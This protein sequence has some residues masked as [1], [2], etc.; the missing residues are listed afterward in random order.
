M[1]PITTEINR[2]VNFFP[3]RPNPYVAGQPGAFLYSGNS[4]T[5]ACTDCNFR[6]ELSLCRFG[7]RIGV[8]YSINDKTVLRAGWGLIYGPTSVNPLGVNA[9][10]IVNTL[11]KA[12]LAKAYRPRPWP[13][14]YRWFLHFLRNRCRWLPTVQ[15]GPPHRRRVPL[16]LTPDGLPDR[17]EWSVGIQRELHEGS[18]A[19]TFPTL[20][21]AVSGGKHLRLVDINAVHIPNSWWR[22]GLI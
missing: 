6:T 9:A 1:A 7:P 22:T 20:P 14:G 18:G 4:G 19:R 13:W 21:I 8:A 11:T 15:S 17:I 2:A 3:N 10:G 5:G 12:S 16:I